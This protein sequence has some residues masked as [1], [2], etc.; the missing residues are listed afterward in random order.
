VITR[1]RIREATVN[2]ETWI[3]S[4]EAAAKLT[5]Q[6]KVQVKRTFKGKDSSEN[7]HQPVTKQNSNTTRMFVDP[8]KQQEWLQRPAT[9][10]MT[11]SPLKTCRKSLKH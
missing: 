10:P 4:Q 11:G 2:E 1:R 3:I 5:E 8:T 7:I 6:K 9:L